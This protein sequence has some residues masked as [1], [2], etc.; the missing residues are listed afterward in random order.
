V[1]KK[2]ESIQLCLDIDE[3]EL[4]LKDITQTKAYQ[5][6]IIL[7]QL[8]FNNDEEEITKQA[9]FHADNCKDGL[10]IM[11]AKGQLIVKHIQATSIQSNSHS[12]IK[13]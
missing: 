5:S 3:A 8:V 6:L 4:K 2:R 11:M 7:L 12:K 9:L 1:A 10:N 13:N